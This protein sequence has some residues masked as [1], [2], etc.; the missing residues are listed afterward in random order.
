MKNIENE[1]IGKIYFTSFEDARNI[2]KQNDDFDIKLHI[3]RHKNKGLL[4]D[5]IHVPQLAPSNELFNKTMYK[6]KKLKFTDKER[7]IIKSG[8]TGTWLDLYVPEFNNEMDTREDFIKCYNRIKEHLNNGKNI[9]A[10]CYCED[11]DKCHRKIISD[12]LKSE[13]FN[14]TCK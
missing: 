5:F 4:K 9:I 8:E 1:N 7:E 2:L 11:K 10:V 6:W 13:G 3:T 12:R 14:S